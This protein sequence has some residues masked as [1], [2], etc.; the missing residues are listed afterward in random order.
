MFN[1]DIIYKTERN[2]LILFY[3]LKINQIECIFVLSTCEDGEIGRHAILRGWC[4][5][6]M[7]VRVS[8]FAQKKLFPYGD[9][10]FYFYNFSYASLSCLK[11]RSTTLREQ[12]TFILINP[13]P[14]FPNISPSLKARPALLQKKSFS[15]L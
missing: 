10:F 2:K 15:S 8:F 13:I 5:T 1:L 3:I 6:G 14:S 4:P 7:G 11:A 12:P 9:S